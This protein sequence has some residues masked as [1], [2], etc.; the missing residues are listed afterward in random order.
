MPTISNLTPKTEAARPK[1][2]PRRRQSA[3]VAAR[4]GA[5]TPPPR[6]PPRALTGT[7]E[8]AAEDDD[9]GPQ[10]PPDPETRARPKRRTFTTPY[11]RKIILEASAMS[12]SERGFSPKISPASGI[13]AAL[14]RLELV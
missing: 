10:A 12:P 8:A 6:T 5:P 4:S 7:P 14:P 13:P 3:K 1:T 11:K 9:R 2:P